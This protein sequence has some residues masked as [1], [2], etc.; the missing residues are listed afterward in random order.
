MS[1]YLA[2]HNDLQ[3]LARLIVNLLIENTVLRLIPCC[4]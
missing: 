3:F 2:R 1:N 4:R